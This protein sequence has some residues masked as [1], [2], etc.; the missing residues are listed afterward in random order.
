MANDEFRVTIT[1]HDPEL[2]KCFEEWW[3]KEGW[4]MFCQWRSKGNEE[5]D[6]FMAGLME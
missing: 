6:A 1:L 2:A 4:A 3:L 5:W